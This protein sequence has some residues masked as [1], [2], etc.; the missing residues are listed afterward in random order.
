MKI[1]RKVSAY[2]LQELLV[3]LVIIGILILIAMPNFMGMINRAKSVEAQQHLKTLYE[4]Q[5]SYYFMNNKYSLNF[6]DIDF[7]PPKTTEQGGTANYSYE[8]LEATNS[9]FKARAIAL[10]DGDGDGVKS[11]WEIDETGTP[12]EIVKD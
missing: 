6:N 4:F 1:K 3:V 12:R 2:N 5:R 10:F 7:E 9:T 8:I 11:T